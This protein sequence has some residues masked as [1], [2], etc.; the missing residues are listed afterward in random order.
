MPRPV[1]SALVAYIATMMSTTAEAPTLTLGPIVIDGSIPVLLMYRREPGGHVR[2]LLQIVVGR[3]PARLS[4]EVQTELRTQLFG[5]FLAAS[6]ST[7]A[8]EKE[9]HLQELMGGQV[10]H[11]GFA[12]IQLANGFAAA[13]MFLVLAASAFLLSPEWPRWSWRRQWALRRPCA[14]SLAQGA[15]QLCCHFRFLGSP[16]AAG[17]AES[18]RTAEEVEVLGA[19][20]SERARISSLVE[21]TPGAISLRL[22]T[23][24]STM[25]VVYQSAVILLIVAGLALVL[26]AVGTSRLAALGRSSSCSSEPP[27]TASS[28]R[29]RTRMSG[30]RFHTLIH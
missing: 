24:I 27:P 18:V 1:C 28:S 12:V 15:A 20:E 7:K 17:V 8:D 26:Y 5:S 9:G 30:R 14:P 3:L 19:A 21:S 25:P 6:W 11:A 4:G 23:L 13:L 29:P 10:M 22:R 2:L 16:Q